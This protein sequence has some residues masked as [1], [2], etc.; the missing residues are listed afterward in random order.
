[1]SG[2]KLNPVF[3]TGTDTGVGKTMVVGLLADYLAK[4][5]IDVITQ[6][7]VQTGCDD[8]NSSDVAAHL[9]LMNKNTGLVEG[10]M[11]YC[12]KGAY[13][14]HLAA[15][16]DGITI[17]I[18]KIKADFE[19]LKK[20]HQSLIVE[21]AGGVY[22]PL[23]DFNL[24]MDLVIRLNMPV[25]IVAQNRLGAINH[26]LL[27]IEYLRVRK[28]KTLGIIFNDRQ[29]ED[30]QVLKDNPRIINQIS[31]CP[32]LGVLPFCGIITELKSAFVPI[33]EKIWQAL[34]R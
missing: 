11:P 33:G 25:I 6:K 5:S 22:V 13:A 23:N 18:E 1:M 19:H 16:K 7:W 26:T 4:N 34:R 20:E 9:K 21:G 14:P 8:I 17:N 15:Q 28:I 29:G 31:A 3:I 2:N 24:M 12:F 27:T 10:Q 30:E 32:V